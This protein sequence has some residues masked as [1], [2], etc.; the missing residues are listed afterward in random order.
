M[1]DDVTGGYPNGKIDG[2]IQGHIRDGVLH[3]TW[4]EG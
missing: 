4:R 1:G 3:F 2:F